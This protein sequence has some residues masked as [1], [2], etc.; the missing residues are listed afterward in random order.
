MRATSGSRAPARCRSRSTALDAL[1]EKTAAAGRSSTRRFARRATA[2][3]E[4]VAWLEAAGAVEDRPL[5]HRQG[6]LHLGLRNVHLV[7]MTWDE[8]VDLLK[9]ELAR[10]HASLRLEEQRNRALP[11]LPAIATPE[12]YQRRANDAVTQVTSPSCAT[13]TS[14]RCATTWTRRC[15]RRSASSCRSRRATSSRSRATTSR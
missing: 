6:E 2:T 1:A 10:A 11:Q 3:V 14:S 4:F 5:R 9:R 7:P 15:A 12:E 8:E 13:G